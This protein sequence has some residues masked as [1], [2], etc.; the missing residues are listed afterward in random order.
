MI[1]CTEGNLQIS[2]PPTARVRKFDD[3]THGL[4]HCMKAVDFIVEYD[5]KYYFIEFKDPYASG[6]P[7][8]ERAKFLEQFLDGKIDED[9][10]YKYRDTFLYEWASEHIDKPI[11][12]CVLVAIDTLTPADLL[13]RTDALKRKIPLEGP[14]S[15]VWKR[16]FITGCAV[17]N[18][19]TWNQRLPAFPVKRIQGA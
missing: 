1:V 14:A 4:S 16:H 17:F 13:N 7:D 10:K 18:I 3:I 11:Y 5:K 9:L 6:I 19:A 15:G 12:Y 2:F 8:K